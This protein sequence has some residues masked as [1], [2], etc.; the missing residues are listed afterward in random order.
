MTNPADAQ[1]AQAREIAERIIEEC[2]GP[3]DVRDEDAVID[4]IAA[5]I[6]EATAALREENARLI[7]I[8]AA[9]FRLSGADP[10]GNEDW[11]LADEAIRAV[12]DLRHDYDDAGKY[13]EAEKARAE[14]A[15]AKLT[16]LTTERDTLREALERI[17]ALKSDCDCGE[18][19][20]SIARAALK[21]PR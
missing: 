7:E 16:A 13:Y 19:A 8:A 2:V 9:C 14:A 10:D 3:L 11:R 5:I 12:S 15:E 1:R 17:A 4:G 21:E 18:C 6:L 20:E